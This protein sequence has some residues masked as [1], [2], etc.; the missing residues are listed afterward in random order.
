MS[1]TLW[2]LDHEKRA[3]C[4]LTILG[5]QKQTMVRALIMKLQISLT[6]GLKNTHWYLT[7][8]LFFIT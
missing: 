5:S 8:P 4:L 7:I 1:F 2:S 3:L 6:Y